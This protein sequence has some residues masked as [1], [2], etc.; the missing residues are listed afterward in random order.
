MIKEKYL[1]NKD[2]TQLNEKWKSILL[3]LKEKRE[4]RDKEQKET[5][6]NKQK[7]EKEKLLLIQKEF[8]DDTNISPDIV[9]IKEKRELTKVKRT[10]KKFILD[11]E[12]N[13]TLLRGL[14]DGAGNISLIV[15]PCASGK[16]YS[17]NELFKMDKERA[18]MDPSISYVNLFINPARIMNIQN[19]NIYNFDTLIKETSSK[20]LSLNKNYSLVPELF[21]KVKDFIISEVNEAIKNNKDK[22]IK[23]N[24][25]GDESQEIL[26][27]RLY[28]EG[29]R[30]LTKDISDLFKIKAD[31]NVFYMTGTPDG[32]SSL[33]DLGINLV[34]EFTPEE[35]HITAKNLRVY[36]IGEKDDEANALLTL[37]SKQDNSMSKINSKAAIEDIK[38][39]LES[40]EKTVNTVTSNDKEYFYETDEENNE[41]I[42]HYKNATI[43]SITTSEK[44]LEGITLSTSVIQAGTNNKF[45]PEGFEENIIVYPYD[46]DYENIIQYAARTRQTYES[47]NIIIK[48]NGKPS[49][50][51]TREEIYKEEWEN[52]MVEK[53]AV[54]KYINMLISD[55][56][57]IKRNTGY[58]KEKILGIMYQDI[59]EYMKTMKHFGEEV[60][61]HSVLSVN[62]SFVVDVDML[63]FE[64]YVWV[65]YTSQFYNNPKELVKKIT[66]KLHFENEPEFIN[67]SITEKI[68][69]VEKLSQREEA[70]LSLETLS[71]DD[72]EVLKMVIEDKISISDIED[73]D[74]R[75]RIKAITDYKQYKKFIKEYMYYGASF[76]KII[77]EI[78]NCKN[79]KTLVKAAKKFKY[80]RGIFLNK[81]F[82][83]YNTV[84]FIEDNAVLKKF[85][86]LNKSGNVIRTKVTDTEI[87]ELIKDI[88]SK[89]GRKFR[90]AE[91]VN[92]IKNHFVV[93]KS[94]KN[95]IIRRL[96]LEESSK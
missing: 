17:I 43:Q 94:D 92:I 6:K 72:E 82:L 40:K 46:C 54:E 3:D 96:R 86:K 38:K 13:L 51:L 45:A 35:K 15:S 73:E 48:S 70:N 4:L 22:R 56:K 71:K 57:T 1:M 61:F 32:V 26:N 41:N 87:N 11:N 90:K 2:N 44:V 9:E 33:E 20:K 34:I 25:V 36:L 75:L 74:L 89:S 79:E 27:S 81:I 78:K 67:L 58:S 29:M 19:G 24:I 91:I 10:Y 16:T 80:A 47:L 68:E 8:E 42:V 62:K 63:T 39:A 12:D 64:A 37:V 95:Y 52:M 23:V 69:E 83:K 50:I 66:D 60:N 5:L 55:I 76:E 77:A 21:P 65:K 93:E 88:E 53:K 31:V 84:Q 7:E 14:L 30:Q 49:H 59:Q 28:R 18:I 85:Y